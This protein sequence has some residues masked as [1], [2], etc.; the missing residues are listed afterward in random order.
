MSGRRRT[1]RLLV[2]LLLTLGLMFSIFGFSGLV[3]LSPA[4]PASASGS[5]TVIEV[6]GA[7]NLTCSDLAR[8]YAPGVT[9]T[10]LKIDPPANTTMSDGTLSVTVSNFTGKFFDW[11]SNTIPVDAVFV[12]AGAA[13]SNLYLYSPAAMSGSSLTSPGETGNNI[14]HIAFC[15]QVYPPTATPTATQEP[16]STATAEPTSTPTVEPTLTPT[17][18]P[19]LTPTVEPT[20]TP[21]VEPTATPTE[22]PTSTP[23]T[24]PT[25]TPTPSPTGTPEIE[26]TATVV[27]PTAT[28]NT[29]DP[30]STP[31]PPTATPNS[32]DPTSTPVQPT[33]TPEPTATP[34]LETQEVIILAETPEAIVLADPPLVVSRLPSAGLGGMAAAVEP[35][36]AMAT[37]MALAALRLL[38]ATRSGRKE[39]R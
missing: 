24:V 15:Y 39:D 22:E 8:T 5:V 38:Y 4:A 33:S 14:S 18:E 36:L 11:S 37:T 17:V 12:K 20:L 1:P 19:T 28:P 7:A 6:P 26:H 23:T 27:P 35:P 16:T 13:G 21:T 30:T 3:G 9:W 2:T 25:S 31:V 29:P 32:P 34:E 10:E